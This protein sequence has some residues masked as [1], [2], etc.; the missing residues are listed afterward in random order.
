MRFF[1]SQPTSLVF[2]LKGKFIMTQEEFE[3]LKE[4][5]N[6]K[7]IINDLNILTKTQTLSKTLQ[8]Y[9]TIFVSE[10][11]TLKTLKTN[12]DHL[13]GQLYKHYKENYNVELESKHEYETY[14]LGDEKYYNL[15]LE[16]NKQEIIVKFLEETIDNI[17][18]LSFNIKNWLE[19]KKYFEG[20]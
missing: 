16:L 6:K 19:I 8:D 1:E 9:I 20:Q 11:E 2:E 4:S 12:Q 13:Y 15:T 10:Y 3:Q 7:F 14:I 5:T 17:K 18:K